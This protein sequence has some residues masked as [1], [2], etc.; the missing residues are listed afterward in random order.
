SRSHDIC[1][2][3]YPAAL[4]CSSGLLGT[5]PACRPHRP[6]NHVAPFLRIFPISAGL[7]IVQAAAGRPFFQRSGAGKTGLQSDRWSSGAAETSELFRQARA[8]VI[9]LKPAT[10]FHCNST[11]SA[12]LGL[13]R[14]A[15]STRWY[16]NSS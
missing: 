7:L 6:R 4:G 13:G 5:R 15:A 1:H 2:D 14:R 9:L 16:A 3:R 12:A 10:P 8:F 11:A